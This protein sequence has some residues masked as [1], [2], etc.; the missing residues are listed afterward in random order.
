MRT[1]RACLAVQGSVFNDNYP[2]LA[3]D[4]DPATCAATGWETIG[5]WWKVDLGSRKTVTGVTLTGT[6]STTCKRALSIIG[7]ACVQI[8]RLFATHAERQTDVLLHKT[9]LY[10]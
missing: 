1:A 3:L 5:P 8:L 6:Y 2:H 7:C 9:S 10:Y 4:K